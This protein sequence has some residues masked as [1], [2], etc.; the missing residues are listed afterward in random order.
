MPPKSKSKRSTKK[1]TTEV[2][3]EKVSRSKKIKRLPKAESKAPPKSTGKTAKTASKKKKAEPK[4]EKKKVENKGYTPQQMEKFKTLLKEI[5]N[6]YTIDEM[7]NILRKNDQ[8]VTGTKKELVERIADG[9]LLGK[10][11]RCPLCFGGRLQFNNKTGVY[12]CPGY[13]EDVKYIRCKGAF[14]RDFIQREQWTE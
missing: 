13:F 1:Q 2:T 7:K 4:V 11:P 14:D 12:K 3:V 6:K 9:E 10:I 5:E 8:K